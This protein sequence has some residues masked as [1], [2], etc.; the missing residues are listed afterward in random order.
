L[1]TKPKDIEISLENLKVKLVAGS[2]LE[3][4]VYTLLIPILLYTVCIVA[5][6][7]QQVVSEL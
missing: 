1:P 7:Y 4:Q 3:Q 6:Q 5:W 2:L